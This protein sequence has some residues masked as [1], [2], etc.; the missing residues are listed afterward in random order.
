MTRM[1]TTMEALRRPDPSRRWYGRPVA[2]VLAGV[3]VLICV[4]MALLAQESSE[5]K[6][7]RMTCGSCPEGYATTG[8]TTDAKI[9]KDGDPTVVQCVPLGANILSVCGSCP[10]GYRQVGSSSNPPRCGNTDGGR[11]TQCQ[12]ENMQS[13]LPDPSQGGITCPPHCGSTVAPGQGAMPP[14]PK[15][16]PTP[17][18]KSE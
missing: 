12:L 17:E 7:T 1:R 3:M 8:V 15:F 11:M 6:S 2:G 4:P 16:R 13:N 9:C 10:D 14:P 5:P 18:K